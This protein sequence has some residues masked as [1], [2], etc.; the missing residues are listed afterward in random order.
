MLAVKFLE[1]KGVI[2]SFG[3]ALLA[4]P[5][6]NA[7]MFIILQKSQKNIAVQ[8]LSFW[9]VVTSGTPLHYTLAICSLIIGVVMLTGSKKAWSFVLGLLGAHILIQLMHLGENIRQNW[10][11]GVFF[12]I[13]AGVFIFIADQLVFKLKV[14]DSPTPQKP[15]QQPSVIAINQDIKPKKLSPVAIG[16][17]GHGAWAELVEVDNMQIQVRKFKEPP[18]DI[19]SRIVEFSFKKGVTLKAKYKN[20]VGPDYYF[21]FIQMNSSDFQELNLWIEKNAS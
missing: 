19:Q 1:R 12:V 4:A 5:F 13:N 20:H 3:A 2:Q 14:P 15:I 16:F 7:L 8:N 21:S 11:W 9:K 10:L 6:A 18:T 17:R